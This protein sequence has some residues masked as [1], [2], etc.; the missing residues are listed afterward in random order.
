MPTYT[1]IDTCI[2]PIPKYTILLRKSPL[3]KG[4]FGVATAS[5]HS[6]YRVFVDQCSVDKMTRTPTKNNRET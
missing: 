3:L 6:L 5:L 1:H 4:P 2:D